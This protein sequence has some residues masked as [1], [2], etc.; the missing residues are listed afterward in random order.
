MGV[1]CLNIT[2]NGESRS[3]KSESSKF[4]FV[5]IF[6]YVDF[7]LSNPKG[8]IVLKLNGKSAGFTDIISPGDVIDI[9][10]DKLF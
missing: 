9:Y 5:D 7:D 6:N 4:I 3:I 10:W 2:V 1:D 8:N